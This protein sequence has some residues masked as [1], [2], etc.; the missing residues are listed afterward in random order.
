MKKQWCWRK[1][2]CDEGGAWRETAG[3]SKEAQVVRLRENAGL[4]WIDIPDRMKLWA[5]QLWRK[6]GI[7]VWWFYLSQEIWEAIWCDGLWGTGI[8]RHGN[9]RASLINTEIIS[10]LLFFQPWTKDLVCNEPQIEKVVPSWLGSHQQI[11][12]KIMT[13][14][15]LMI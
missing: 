12:C 7:W 10:L 5:V 1:W 2:R 6:K 13:C 9:Y 4:S 11:Q 14:F 15:L 8:E 3:G